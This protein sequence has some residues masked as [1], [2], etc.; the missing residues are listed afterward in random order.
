MR[1]LFGVDQPLDRFVFIR[2]MINVTF[3]TTYNSNQTKRAAHPVWQIDCPNPE[4][5]PDRHFEYHYPDRPTSGS[6]SGRPRDIGIFS[7]EILGVGLTKVDDLFD[8]K[9]SNLIECIVRSNV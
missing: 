7:S 2:D 3:R 5:L 4:R 6:Q 1:A 8:H 9:K